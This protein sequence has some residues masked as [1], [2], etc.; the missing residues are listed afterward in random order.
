MNHRPALCTQPYHHSRGK[1]LR[2][3]PSVAGIQ[4]VKSLV[5]GDA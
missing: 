1:E 3:E 2:E 5:Q 4:V